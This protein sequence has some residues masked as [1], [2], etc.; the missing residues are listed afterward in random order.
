MTHP[1]LSFRYT[2]GKSPDVLLLLHGFL[3]CKED[4]ETLEKAIGPD[5]SYLTTDLPG[6]AETAGIALAPESYRMEKCAKLV[7]DTINHVG[8]SSCHLLGYSMGGRLALFLALHYPDRFRSLMIESATAGIRNETERTE[9]RARD[10]KL[11]QTIRD[12]NLADFLEFWYSQPLFATLDPQSQSYKLMYERRL[13]SD[14][15]GLALS[16]EQMGTGAQPDLWDHLNELKIPALFM[17]GARDWKFQRL[18]AE[19]ANLCPGGE[20]AILAEAG[21]N[22]HFE[23]PE[24]FGQTVSAF[25]R[26]GAKK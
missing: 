10:A 5:Q 13:G 17:A 22:V 1:M 4:W 19:M 6:H 7:I 3:G 11:A 18:A 26:S 21:H 2:Q 15:E 16:L 8:L 12:R 9:R 24:E 20:V 23:K 14:R 25:I